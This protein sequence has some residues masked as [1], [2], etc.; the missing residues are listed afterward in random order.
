M[1]KSR[2]AAS[3]TLFLAIKAALTTSV[4]LETPFN[5]YLLFKLCMW[6]FYIAFSKGP[7]SFNPDAQQTCSVQEE[8]F[9]NEFHL[10]DLRVY[11]N[12]RK[13]VK[14]CEHVFNLAADMGGMGFIQSNHSVIMYNNTMISFN[15][16]EVSRVEGVK[17]CSLSLQRACPVCYLSQCKKV[18]ILCIEIRVI[19]CTTGCLRDALW[20][21]HLTS[22]KRAIFMDLQILLC[23]ERMHL[24]REQTAEHRSRRRRP[25]RGTCLASTGTKLALLISPLEKMAQMV[26]L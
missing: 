15:M 9:C 24:P 13:I 6:A 5:H 23:L 26:M 16:V 20:Q 4:L 14:G 12:C 11:D 25:E 21:L 2:K 18:A 3:S 1:L 7:H 10:V 8:I 17:R 19:C 22:Q